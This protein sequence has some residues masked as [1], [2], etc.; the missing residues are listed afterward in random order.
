MVYLDQN[1]CNNGIGGPMA[2]AIYSK[3]DCMCK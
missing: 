1:N 3:I 2:N